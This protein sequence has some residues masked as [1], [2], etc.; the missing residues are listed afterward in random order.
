MQDFFWADYNEKD[1]LFVSWRDRRNA[2]ESGFEIAFE[3]WGAFKLKGLQNY[4][5]N[6]YREIK[7]IYSQTARHQYQS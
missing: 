2:Q 5:K 1:D 7:A 4:E 6:P 3:I